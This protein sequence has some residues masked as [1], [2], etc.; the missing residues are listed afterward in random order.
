MFQDSLG[1]WVA[2]ISIGGREH[3]RRITRYADTEAAAREA[4]RRL[5]AENV[6]TVAHDGAMLTLEDAITAWLNEQKPRIR[7]KSWVGYEGTL[8]KHVVEAAPV[9]AQ[10]RLDRIKPMHVRAHFERLERIGTSPRVRELVFL[11]L[12]S[13]FARWIG[14]GVLR[15]PVER[16]HRPRVERKT[17]ATWT[18][19]QARAFLDATSDDWLA[20]LYRLA[21]SVGMRRGEL[22]GL[23]WSDVDL[24]AHRIH[25]Q[26]TATEAGAIAEAK[27]HGS[28]RTIELPSRAAAAIAKQR[29]TLLAKGL[30]ATPW[31]FPTEQGEPYLARRLTRQFDDAIARANVPRIRFHDLRHTAATLMLQAGVNVKVVS[32]ILGH[33]QSDITLNLYA[34]VLP[35]M[36]AEAADRMDSL[37]G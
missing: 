2:K 27:T 15:N 32:S 35:G 4:L 21:L 11:R 22:L 7:A 36:G 5:R 1:R 20:P 26:H 6:E 17:M 18:Q 34:H 13:L 12:R 30:R 10:M 23:R 24:K 25:V 28:R 9:F 29:A 14:A 31:V 16:S 19:E 33:A 3:R 37:L 8:R